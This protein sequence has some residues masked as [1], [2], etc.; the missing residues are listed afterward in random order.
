MIHI[1][2]EGAAQLL[3]VELL[4]ENVLFDLDQVHR[5]REGTLSISMIKFDHFACVVVAT[6]RLFIRREQS[7]AIMTTAECR[8]LGSCPLLK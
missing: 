3:S 7:G 4:M 6:P 8:E 2:S 1:E 5:H